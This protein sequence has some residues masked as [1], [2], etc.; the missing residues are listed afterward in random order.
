MSEVYPNELDH[1]LG[2]I[3]ESWVSHIFFLTI[4]RT[5]GIKLESVVSEKNVLHKTV[6]WDA[7]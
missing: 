5:F 4:N 1:T 7:I 6:H 3:L 2:H